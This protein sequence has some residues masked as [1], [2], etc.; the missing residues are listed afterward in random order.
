MNEEYINR[1][2]ELYFDGSTTLQQEEELRRILADAR[3]PYSPQIESALAVMG[4]TAV[5]Q[6]SRA[7]ARP[8]ILRRS[9]MAMMAASVSIMLAVGI[10]WMFVS[11]RYNPDNSC[12]AYV[13]GEKVVSAEEVMMIM[14]SQL[15][16]ISM[17]QDN[18][19]S[20][21]MEQHREISEI[22]NQL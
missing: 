19:E 9:R 1:L 8:S 13:G 16:S 3:P 14:D 18:F 2:I 22:F 11:G 20:E 5:M 12:V 15:N 10:C 17:A 7:V 6:P 21:L 4:Y